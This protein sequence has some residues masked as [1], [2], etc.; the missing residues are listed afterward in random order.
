VRDL[1]EFAFRAVDLEP[2]EYVR[3][4]PELARPAE[5]QEVVAD[6]SKAKSILGWQP[7]VTCEEVIELM[8]QADLER[9]GSP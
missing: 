5:I 7:K 4:D 9:L 6:A 3:I 2:E 1:V 8:V